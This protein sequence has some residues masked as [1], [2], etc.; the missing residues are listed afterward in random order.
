MDAN[1]DGIKKSTELLHNDMEKFD[2]SKDVLDAT[3]DILK[4]LCALEKRVSKLEDEN[5]KL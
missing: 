5:K 2:V 1:M 3:K 4:S